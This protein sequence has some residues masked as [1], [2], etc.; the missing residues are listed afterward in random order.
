MKIL[1]ALL[2]IIFSNTARYE[3]LKTDEYRRQTSQILGVWSI[4]STIIGVACA[5]LGIWAISAL[6]DALG[7]MDSLATLLIAIGLFLLIILLIG[8]ILQLIVNGLMCA[9]LQ[10]RLN[11]KPIGLV[12]LIL[13][14]LFI[15]AA[16][17]IVVVLIF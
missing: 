8:V 14:F 12:S 11:K 1:H 2:G 17:V 6:A 5:V 7:S 4:L 15:I 10:M 9:V 13:W 3:R 16:V